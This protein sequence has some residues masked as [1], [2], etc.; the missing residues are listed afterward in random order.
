MPLDPEQLRAKLEPIFE[1]LVDGFFVLLERLPNIRFWIVPR[2]MESLRWVARHEPGLNA[3]ERE[4]IIQE[5]TYVEQRLMRGAPGAGSPRLA[6]TMRGIGPLVRYLRYT[7]ARRESEIS[8]YLQGLP[9][10][11][12]W[13]ERQVKELLSLLEHWRVLELELLP[14]S[15]WP[16]YRLGSLSRPQLDGLERFGGFRE[17]LGTQAPRSDGAAI[18]K[19]FVGEIRGVL[20]PKHYQAFTESVLLFARHEFTRMLQESRPGHREEIPRHGVKVM[21]GFRPIH[22]HGEEALRSSPRGRLPTR[23]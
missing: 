18:S 1:R 21:L 14:G 4:L 20:N 16:M 5:L 12:Q 9:E 15:D 2:L 6:E 17:P 11:A 19:H 8:L 23:H 13:N 22:L 10:C 7:G 3:R